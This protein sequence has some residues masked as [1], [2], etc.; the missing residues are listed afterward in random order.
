MKLRLLFILSINLTLAVNTAQA[1]TDSTR[2]SGLEIAIDYGKLLTI[3]TDFEAKAE[4]SLGYR[5]KGRFIPQIQLGM[6]QLDPG[7]AFENGTYHSEGYYGT[8]GINYLLPIDATN[9]LYIGAQY[10]MSMYEDNYE[11]T[12]ASAIW[13]D[14]TESVSRTDLSAD[15]VAIVIGSEKKLRIKGLYLGGEF[16]L[17]ILNSYDQFEP[18]DT[19]AIPGYGRT[20]DSTVPA[21]NLYLKY[22]IN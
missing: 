14:F 17:R 19:Y 3:A 2:L 16:N 5:I 21:V 22:L 12:I 11:Y 10:G 13:P 7:T 9:S 8:A 1:Q 18:I 4:I 6:A 20:A 15:W